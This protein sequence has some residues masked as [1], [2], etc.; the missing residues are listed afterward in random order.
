MKSFEQQIDELAGII[1]KNKNICVFSG[2][3]ISVPSGIPDFRSTGGLY[4]TQD[5][6]GYSP[7]EMI[8]HTFFVQKPEIFYRFYKEKMI[9]K[10]A[11][12]NIAHRFFPLLEQAGKQVPIVT[13]NID[14]LHTLAGSKEVFELHGSIYRNYCT[15]CGTF[16]GLDEVLSQQGVPHCKKDSGII[17]PDVV[18]YEEPL[19]G[20]TIQKAVSAIANAEVLIVVGTSLTVYP[21]AS[22]VEYF[23]GKHI[24]VMN[25]STTHLDHSAEFVFDCGAEVCTQRLGE[26]LGLL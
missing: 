4:S 24:A 7:E 26:I 25:K 5:E 18:L 3:G 22:F 15:T 6:S 10:D 11:R 21:A 17:K 13:Q 14:G 12:P 2:A 1:E 16:Y 9:Y 19:D 23:R 8:S 20:D